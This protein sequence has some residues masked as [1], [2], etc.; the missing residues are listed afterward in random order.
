MRSPFS[1]FNNDKTTLF[2]DSTQEPPAAAQPQIKFIQQT[3]K[4]SDNIPKLKA[5][6]KYNAP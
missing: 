1:L 6:H 3:V 4:L 5:N 2:Q